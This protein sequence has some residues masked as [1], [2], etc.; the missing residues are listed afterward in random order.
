EPSRDGGTV[1][2]AARRDRDS[3]VVSVTDTGAGVG[4]SPDP[5][6]GVGLSNVRE[7]LAALYGSRGRFELRSVTPRGARATLAVPY[8]E[9][10]A[11]AT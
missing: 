8:E 3:L 6:R 10:P 1:M 5:G 4:T 7:R 2:L 11:L 9:A